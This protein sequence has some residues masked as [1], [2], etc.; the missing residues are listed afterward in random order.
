MKIAPGI[1]GYCCLKGYSAV[2]FHK[3]G[4]VAVSINFRVDKFLSVS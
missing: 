4:K 1:G 3:D 2:L